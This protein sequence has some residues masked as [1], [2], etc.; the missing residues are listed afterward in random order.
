MIKKLICKWKG[1]NLDELKQRWDINLV[2]GKK[3]LQNN[4]IYWKK[5]QEF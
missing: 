1:H 4:Q 3:I 2:N 5:M